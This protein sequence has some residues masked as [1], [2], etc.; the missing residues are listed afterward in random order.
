M[1]G[2][3]P[4]KPEEWPGDGYRRPDDVSSYAMQKL[5]KN[6]PFVNVSTNCM[7]LRWDA[8]YATVHDSMVL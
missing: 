4:Q 8:V 1:G 6:W 5:P 7:F 3:E 2:T